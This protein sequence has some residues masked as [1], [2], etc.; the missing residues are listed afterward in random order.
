MLDLVQANEKQ[1]KFTILEF[2]IL[3]IFR[4]SLKMMAIQSLQ[5]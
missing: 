2:D 5:K 4:S 3:E 1:I